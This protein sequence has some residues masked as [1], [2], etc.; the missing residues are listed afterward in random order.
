[1]SLTIPYS[2]GTIYPARVYLM[3]TALRN[4]EAGELVNSQDVELDG[5]NLWTTDYGGSTA[6][7]ILRTMHYIRNSQSKPLEETPIKALT[8]YCA[9]CGLIIESEV[10][11]KHVDV[12][13]S[14]IQQTACVDIHFHN[15]ACH[16][17]WIVKNTEFLSSGGH[18]Q[19]YF[20]EDDKQI[21]LLCAPQQ[22]VSR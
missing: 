10:M 6:A 17:F 1:M 5:N 9:A 8:L 7:D 20:M 2:N 18:A 21:T 14:S 4:I 12:F 13:V 16:T 15:E 19:K 22:K 11:S 3:G